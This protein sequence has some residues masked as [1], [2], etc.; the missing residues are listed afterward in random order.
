[1]CLYKTSVLLQVEFIYRLIKQLLTFG[2]NG[3]QQSKIW[4]EECCFLV[5][6]IKKLIS[7]CYSVEI[8]KLLSKNVNH[9]LL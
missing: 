8:V 1:M 3:F 2:G 9:S 7:F 5:V 4:F 6:L